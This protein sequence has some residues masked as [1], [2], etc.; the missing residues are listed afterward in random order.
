MTLLVL[1]TIFSFACHKNFKAVIGKTKTSDSYDWQT[2]KT[3]V[4]PYFKKPD[5]IMALGVYNER[6]YLFSGPVKEPFAKT[7]YAYDSFEKH[8]MLWRYENGIY[9]FDN[10]YINESDIRFLPVNKNN[11]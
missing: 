11:D 4:R 3:N 6:Y 5:H 7:G 9:Y 1:A 10:Q 2:A 8:V